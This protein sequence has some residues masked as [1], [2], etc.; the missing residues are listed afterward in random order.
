MNDPGQKVYQ[1][2]V[3]LLYEGDEVPRTR[4]HFFGM[5]LEECE[6]QLT[7]QAEHDKALYALFVRGKDEY[8]GL[9]AR[10]ST[11]LVTLGK[12]RKP[13]LGYR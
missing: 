1:L 12:V 8:E 13:E 9:I 7:E 11:K 6:E 2:T 10:T 4:F 5:T 3:D